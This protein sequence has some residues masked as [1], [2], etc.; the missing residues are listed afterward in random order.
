M[1]YFC[2]TCDLQSESKYSINRHVIEQHSGFSWQCVSCRRKLRKKGEE[3]SPCGREGKSRCFHQKT[4]TEGEDAEKLYKEYC[5]K[6]LPNAVLQI[7]VPRAT[8]SNIKDREIFK[9]DEDAISLITS[10]EENDFFSPTS[11]NTSPPKKIKV[12]NGDVLKRM[13]NHV[14]LD[15]GGNRFKVSRATLKKAGGV[16]ENLDSVPPLPGSSS[17]SSYFIDRDPKHFPI[18]LNFIRNQAIHPS[19]LPDDHGQLHAIL[20]ECDF[21][22]LKELRDTVEKKLNRCQCKP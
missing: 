11:T 12:D 5:L 6:T 8:P 17:I 19:M 18:I 1:T 9:R 14:I 3:H 21:Y 16:F 20:M 4:K 10:E 7:K 15:V 13:Q 2:K 22:Q